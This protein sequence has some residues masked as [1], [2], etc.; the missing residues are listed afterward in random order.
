MP[1][2]T[3]E[4]YDAL[5]EKWTKNPPTPGPNGTGFFAKRKAALAAQSARSITIDNLSADWLLTKAI[6]AGKTP[7]E[8]IRDMVQKEIAA[9]V[10]A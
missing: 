10:G 5:D 3:E 8:I 7:A 9:S 1:D 2:L 6:A 4:E